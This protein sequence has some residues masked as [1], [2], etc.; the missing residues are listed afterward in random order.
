M[1][2]IEEIIKDFQQE[3]DDLISILI[4][5]Y[6]HIHGKGSFPDETK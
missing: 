4:R 3:C 1:S 5:G 2:E 6:E